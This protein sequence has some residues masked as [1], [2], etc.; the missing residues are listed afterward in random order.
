[1]T[2]S[3]TRFLTISLL[4]SICAGLAAGCRTRGGDPDALSPVDVLQ[5]DYPLASWKN[6]GALDTSVRF[7]DVFFS[8]DSFQIRSSERA[9]LEAV[10]G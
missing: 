1:M 4:I 5:G 7:A 8:F 3:I 9:K 10:A 6:L 2:R